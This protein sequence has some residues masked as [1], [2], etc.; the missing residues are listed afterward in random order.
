MSIDRRNFIRSSAAG[1]VGSILYNADL[2][3]MT[4][5][6]P[7]RLT[8]GG[9]SGDE[10]WW[11]VVKSQ[12]P[13]E[14]NLHYFNN[15]SLGPSPDYVIKNTELYR[16]LLD[17]FPSKYMWGG[18]SADKERVRALIAGYFSADKEEIAV[19]HNTTEGMN[20]FARS[21]DLKEGDEII[22]A[23]HE[24]PTGVNPY[25][26]F[27]KPLGIKLVR[28]VLPLLPESP[29]EIADVYRRAITG[30]TRLIS[31][32]HMTNTN[33]MIL[34]VKQVSELAH[35]SNIIV[36]V[37]G[38]QSAGMFRI[39]LPDLGCDF[40]AASGH[41]WLFGPKGTGILYA[42]REKRHL[43][44][45]MMVSSNWTRSD[46]RM[47]EDYNTR[48]LPGFLGLGLAIEFNN[49]L[50][51]ER[52]QERIYELK[53]YFRGF[54]KDD[55]RFRMMTPASDSLSAGIQVVEIAGK[56]AGDAGKYLA[57]KYH[58]DCR[59]MHTNGLNAL[60]ISLSVFN[61]REDI[62]ILVKAMREFAG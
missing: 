20:L 57:D 61:T 4:S 59:P 26:Y 56:N 11:R 32:V 54:I 27:C 62:D 2:A 33:G 22:L 5:N 48:D 43:L 53:H 16:R 49:L 17:S 1:L 7:S 3:S 55:R 23:D 14:E 34:P 24:H 52:K 21:F 35:K 25:E 51:Q 37:D 47:F 10:E 6:F 36:C 46:I 31:M 40:Y 28:P 50:T 41:K 18:W 39:D 60:R 44:K 45:P 13:L 38:A 12:F 29:E 19:T 9:S 8:R 15:G 42:A 58:I 30:R